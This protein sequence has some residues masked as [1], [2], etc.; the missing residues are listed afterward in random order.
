MFNKMIPS[1][2]SMVAHTPTPPLRAIELLLNKVHSLVVT[3]EVGR[4]RELSP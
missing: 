3:F 2:V 1:G 4:A